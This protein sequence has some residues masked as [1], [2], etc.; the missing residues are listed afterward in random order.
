MV[1]FGKNL[2]D[3][4][5]VGTPDIPDLLNRMKAQAAR[6]PPGGWIV[7]FGYSVPKMKEGRAPTVEELDSISA[8]IPVMIVDNSGHLGAA[9]SAAFAA[10]GVTAASA[11]PA[12]G[13]FTR[14]PD[15]K[16]LAGPMEETALNLVR[17]KRPAFTGKMADD[18]MIGGARMWASMGQTTA[19]D[20]GIGLGEDDMAIVRNAIN[21][22]LLPIDLYVCAKDSITD[23]MLAQANEVRADATA[24]R[25]KLAAR[26]DDDRRYIN[27]VRMG[28]IK[29]W[30]DG[31]LDTAWFTQPYA[32]N[33]PGKTGVY[34]GYRQIEDAT[35]DAAFDR[36]WT[37]DIQINMH[38]QGDA[39]ADQ[40]LNAIEKAARKYGMRDHRPVFIH[41]T[42]LR[43]D[44]I[45]KM[46]RY[47]AV[48][49][50]LTPSIAKAGD[51]AHMEFWQRG[52]GNQGLPS[53][54]LD[55]VMPYITERANHYLE[56][57]ADGD[58]KMNFSTQRELKRA[59]GEMRDEISITWE[60]EGLEDS[61][62][63]SGGQLKKMEIA[64]DLALMDLVA[65]RE[66]G[67]VDLLMMDE[68]LD[69][70]DPEGRQR[71]LH[72]LHELRAKRGSIFV[73]SHDAE[74]AEIFEKS[75]IVVK[76]GGKSSLV[77]T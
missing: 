54:V 45:E 4:D 1:Y 58:I 77:R 56:T 32:N 65:T 46:G 29:F 53:F 21:K 19:Q 20:C 43:P 31:A 13:T 71:V 59:K 8:T 51:L 73:I 38:I 12:G 2:V 62:P 70:L 35:L 16:S 61:Y 68:V 48:P 41:A 49:T 66:G 40:A 76:D 42:V 22:N 47:G 14:K 52:F 30:L 25:V 75:I 60:I 23:P 57:L 6:T 10:A 55:S 17:A 69:G 64:T 44:Q 5:L 24:G 39:A 74:V 50:F 37:T 26:T 28:G 67:S 36:F 63:P 15:G 11:D 3:A 33:P 72:L 7:G 18:V 27:R 34:L 9:N